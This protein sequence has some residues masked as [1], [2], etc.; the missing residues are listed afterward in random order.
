MAFNL[1][2]CWIFM[3]Q[4]MVKIVWLNWSYSHEQS[5]TPF[6]FW[7]QKLTSGDDTQIL[8]ADKKPYSLIEGRMEISIL[9]SLYKA[10]YV[11]FLRS[12]TRK[13]A[14]IYADATRLTLVAAGWRAFRQ[15]KMVACKDNQGDHIHLLLARE[16]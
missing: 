15:T 3:Q 11:F 10:F 13:H 5:V 12:Q 9:A 2:T 8:Q 1:L 7:L 4:M 16:V 14:V 6:P